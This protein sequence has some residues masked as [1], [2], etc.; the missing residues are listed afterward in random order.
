MQPIVVTFPDHS[1]LGQGGV[2]RQ[3][4]LTTAQ[5]VA[6]VQAVVAQQVQLQPF[7]RRIGR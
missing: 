7:H 6:Q 2:V 4:Y 3:P 5:T 1:S